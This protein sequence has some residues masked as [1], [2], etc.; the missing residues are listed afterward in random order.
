M[1]APDFNAAADRH[2]LRCHYIPASLPL[3]APLDMRGD[4]A[5]RWKRYKTLWSNYEIASQLRRQPMELRTATFKTCIGADA[6]EVVEGF[7]YEV[8]EDDTDLETIMAKMEAFCVGELN[9]LY[10]R[11][12]FNKRD[13]GPGESVDTYLAALRSLVKTCNYGSLEESLLRDRI[14]MGIRDNAARKRMLQDSRLTLKG[15]INLCHAHETTDMQMRAM[16]S[17]PS[18]CTESEVN[19]VK[20]KQNQQLG[21]EKEKA[22]VADCAYCGRNHPK[23]KCPAWGKPCAKCGRRNHFARKCMS[24]GRPKGKT[25][26]LSRKTQVKHIAEDEST[27][28]ELILTVDVKDRNSELVHQTQRKMKRPHDDKCKVDIP[29]KLFAVLKMGQP[30]KRLQFQLDCGSTVNVLGEA[31]YKKLFE[32]DGLEGLVPT[33]ATL[34]MFNK[35]ELNPLG[36]G[37]HQR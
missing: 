34:V 18:S 14:V 3:P 26:W 10:E 2:E 21:K 37:L 28:E 9:E 6:L 33:D 12:T 32:D 35:T 24:V 23:G 25:Q 11:Y 19:Y 17:L 30:R 7:K 8:G 20:H 5:G 16:A 36:E 15:A 22:N 29:K 1:S 31:D 27:D 4:V 13:Q